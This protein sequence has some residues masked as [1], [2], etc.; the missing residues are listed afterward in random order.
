MLRANVDRQLAVVCIEAKADESFGGTLVQELAK[1]LSR[2]PKTGLPSRLDWL[3]RLLFNQSVFID[4]T[5]RAI[6]PEFQAFPYQLF[7]AVGGTL[8]EAMRQDAAIAVLV[9][10]EFKTKLTTSQ[11]RRKNELAMEA[12]LTVFLGAHSVMAPRQMNGEMVGPIQVVAR[13][14]L[15][16]PYLRPVPLYLGKLTTVCD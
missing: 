15:N 8:L 11:N 9:I 7:T 4:E 16:P 2:S 10:H 14:D 6:R 12:F 13:P 1:S 3:S 5:L